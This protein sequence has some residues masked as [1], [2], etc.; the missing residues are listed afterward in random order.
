[1]VYIQKEGRPH[2]NYLFIEMCPL[3]E[4]AQQLSTHIY[5]YLL[6]KRKEMFAYSPEGTIKFTD[7]KR[8]SNFL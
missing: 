8:V 1:M 3:S 2:K 4:T 6:N 5:M 7:T